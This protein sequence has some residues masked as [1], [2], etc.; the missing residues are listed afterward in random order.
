MIDFLKER[1]TSK[2]ACTSTILTRCLGMV[3]W[4]NEYVLK[5][6]IPIK[7]LIFAFPVLLVRV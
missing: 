7:K 2:L 3:E 1:G 6:H 4:L 5:Q